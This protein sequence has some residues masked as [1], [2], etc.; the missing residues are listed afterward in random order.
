MFSFYYYNEL[1]ATYSVDEF[2]MKELNHDNVT[3][4][5]GACIDP[6][7]VCILTQLCSKGSIQVRQDLNYLAW[8]V[9]RQ[10][11]GYNRH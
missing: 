3:S 2:Q 10:C 5:V 8:G 9:Y 4:F 6:G 1:F 7:H 11:T